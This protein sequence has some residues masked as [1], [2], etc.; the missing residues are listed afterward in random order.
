MK[1]FFA[2][3][4]LLLASVGVA[5]S[6]LAVVGGTA[7]SFAGYDGQPKTVTGA[8]N[9]GQLGTLSANSAGKFSVT[10]LGQESGYVDGFKFLKVAGTNALYESNALGTTIS[11]DVQPG[12]LN[13]EFWD[14]KKAI[15][16]NGIDPKTDSSSLN[17]YASFAVL[18]GRNLGKYGNFDYIL[19]FND[20]FKGDADYDDFVVGVKLSPVPL[21]AAAWLFAS[22]LFGFVTVSNR[23]RV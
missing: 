10:Y 13:F 22:A 8:Y 2:A 3:T 11:M 18:A 4:V 12:V 7:V 19:G 23:R 20:G 6:S 14:S 1:K 21:P 9:S 17:N 16:I 5:A 15:V